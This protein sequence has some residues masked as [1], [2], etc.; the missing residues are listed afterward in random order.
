M[1]ELAA[2]C[3]RLYVFADGRTVMDGTPAQIF[4]DVPRLQ[5]L[6]LNAPAVTLLCNALVNAQLLPISETIYTY[7]QAIHTLRRHLS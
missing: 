7:E 6:G 3:H 4:A 2:I 1:D 5:A